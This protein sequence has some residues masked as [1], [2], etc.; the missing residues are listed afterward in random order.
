MNPD[1]FVADLERK[2]AVLSRL[3]TSLAAGNPWADVVPPGI[4]RVVLIGM[5]SSAYAGGVAAA[6]MRARG[7][8]AVSD[9]ASSSLLPR[10]GAGTLV[11]ATSATGGS[12]ETLDALE[13]MQAANP[14]ATFVAL[15][16]TPGSA[17]A[18]R[19]GAVVDL[20]ADPEEGGVACRTYQ[21]TVAMLIALEEQLSGGDTSA[22]AGAVA[23]AA[24]AS[25]HL[26]DTE[27]SWRPRVA[28]LLLGPAGTHLAAP[29]HR[30][31]SAQQG[32]LMLRECPRLPAVG[33]E[34]G[35]WSH[36][37]VYLTKTTDYRLLVFAGSP[38]EQQLAEWTTMRKTTVVAVGGDVPS[39][40]FTVRYP[41]D[42]DGDAGDLVRLLTEVLIPELVA[43]RAW[44]ESARNRT[45]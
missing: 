36:V 22:L 34:T 35:D 40:Q 24:T 45:A 9:L 29:A 6:R 1:A 37:D 32:A 17:L 38:W 8:V 21:H 16:N 31:S 30:F 11:V 15:T 18:Q 13:R 5:G 28:D 23:A 44:Q 39:A 10:W 20:A 12:V 19:C 25:A 27:D 4:E 2:P 41:G 14:S 3:A 26:L 33:C 43:A 42:T 7:L